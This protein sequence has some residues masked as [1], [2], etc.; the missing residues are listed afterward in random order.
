MINNQIVIKKNYI[1]L[2]EVLCITI[3]LL[4][5]SFILLLRSGYELYIEI[6]LNSLILIFFFIFSPLVFSAQFSHFRLNSFLYSKPSIL[7][8][9]LIFIFILGW[10]RENFDFNLFFIIYAISIYCIY[11]LYQNND[12]NLNLKFL[13]IYL[14]LF[15]LISIF[16]FTA[17]YSNNYFD[18]LFIEKTATGAFSHRD[19]FL[20]TAISGM[21]KTYNISSIGVDDLISIDYH[22]FSHIFFAIISSLIGSNTIIFYSCII[23]IVVIPLLVLTFLYCIESLNLVYVKIMNNSK[24]IYDQ[25]F[26]ILF[27][28]LFASP[29]SMSL[30]PYDYSYLCSQSFLFGL[31]ISFLIISISTIYLLNINLNKSYFSENFYFT[32][33]F[34]ILFTCLSYSKISFT[35]TLLVAMAYFYFRLNLYKMLSVNSLFLFIAII[36]FYTLYDLV[37]PMLNTN[38]S[39][40]WKTSY[41]ELT[42]TY[43]YY[44]YP[45]LLIIFFQLLN[46]KFIKKIKLKKY[47]YDKKFIDVEI[48][49]ILM[50]VL[51]FVP[52]DYFKQIQLFIAYLIILTNYIEIKKI[53]NKYVF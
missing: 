12:F 47:F 5:V 41:V 39:N 16:F 25:Y 1:G 7:F 31:I 13:F 4:S 29:I 52:Y 46:Y 11:H 20:H 30:S 48:L 43:I 34:L 18:P 9:C 27:L 14:F 22:T 44:I 3:S 35:F 17:Y 45:S 26:Y 32:L 50:I 21:F 8:I 36:S 53:I 38:P 10:I 49:I 2:N 40:N 33:I 6:L 28:I 15:L 24:L 42:K 51:Y 23:P 37:L 19:S